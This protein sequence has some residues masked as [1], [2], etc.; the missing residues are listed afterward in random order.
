MSLIDS[1][2]RPQGV[3]VGV[4]EMKSGEM[5]EEEKRREAVGSHMVEIRESSNPEQHATSQRGSL[6]GG[7]LG[8]L[9]Q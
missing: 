3:G 5:R 9:P 4:K 2:H 8:D 7:R 6:L 1:H